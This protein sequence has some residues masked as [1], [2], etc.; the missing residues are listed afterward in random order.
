MVCNAGRSSVYAEVKP[1]NISPFGFVTKV[2]IGSSVPEQLFAESGAVIFVC[3][4][5]D[6]HPDITQGI[7]R[8]VE[9]FYGLKAV[10]CMQMG[11]E[12]YPD[13]VI[14]LL[15]PVSLAKNRYRRYSEQEY[16]EK[17]GQSLLFSNVQTESGNHITFL[18]PISEF[19]GCEIV[20]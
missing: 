16:E 13:G 17:L 2:K 4:G 5:P 7:R 3:V 15:L 6:V 18:Y 12:G 1:V 11:V 14:C 20:F 9:I 19:S 10:Q 8:P